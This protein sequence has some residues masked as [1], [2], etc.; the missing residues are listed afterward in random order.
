VLVG[1][2]KQ[3]GGLGGIQTGGIELA[4]MGG[5]KTFR[6]LPICLVIE[7]SNRQT[8]PQSPEANQSFSCSAWVR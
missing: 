8:E 5:R 1:I 4:G 2:Q 6:S 3:A 7:A